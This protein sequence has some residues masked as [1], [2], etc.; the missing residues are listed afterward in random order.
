MIYVSVCLNLPTMTDH[1][2][3]D[4]EN[5]PNVVNKKFSLWR[6]I[7]TFINRAILYFKKKRNH[8]DLKRAAI[9][10]AGHVIAGYFT[11]HKVYGVSIIPTGKLVGVTSFNHLYFLDWFSTPFLQVV[12][13]YGGKVAEELFL[14]KP[15]LHFEDQPHIDDLVMKMVT[16][17][18]M[19]KNMGYMNFATASDED[20]KTI[21]KEFKSIKAK[22]RKF[23]TEIIEEHRN[24]F[25]KIV[26]VLM[27]H[28]SLN[29]TEIKEILEGNSSFFS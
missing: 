12:I 19:S 23:V 17:W 27:A 7:R 4:C 2:I 25:L 10:E 1:P 16:K 29:G 22:A 5:L 14:G 3:L 24:G 28:Y 6:K 18:G 15:L 13:R 9:H 26:A 11:D 21:L 20:K 8:D